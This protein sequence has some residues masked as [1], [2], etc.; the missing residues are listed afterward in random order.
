MGFPPQHKTSWVLI[1]G[2]SSGIGEVFA[3]RFAREGWNAVL[4]ARSVDR[5]QAL[6]RILEN[7]NKVKTLAIQADLTD[8]ASSRRIYDEVKR[9][10]ILLEGLVNNAGSGVSGKFAE[11]PLDRYLAMIDLNICSL[12]ELTHRFLPEMISRRQGLILNVS[13]TASFQALP[14]ASVYAATKSFVT[15]FTEALWCETKGTGV[16]ILCLCP[17]LTKTNFGVASGGRDFR[18]DPVAEEPEQVVETAFRALNGNAPTVISG[19]RNRLLIF[20]E[21][22][23]PQ[24]LLLWAAMRIQQSREHV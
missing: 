1:T 19:W 6:A 22:F 18:L 17:G 16:R 15:S 11:A 8:R 21:R 23:T 4:V 2:A 5:L 7:E 20:L 3:K 14:Y 24:R 9:E 10:G 12:V 13:S